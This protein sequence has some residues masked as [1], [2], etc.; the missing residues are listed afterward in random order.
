MEA[1]ATQLLGALA[2]TQ[3]TIDIRNSDNNIILSDGLGNPRL[4]YV[5]ANTE[6]VINEQS[7]NV[8]FRVESND[9]AKYALG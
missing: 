5:S 1:L 2:A 9:D 6:L 3:G 8:D 4:A 7:S